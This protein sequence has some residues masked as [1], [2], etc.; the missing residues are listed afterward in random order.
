MNVQVNNSPPRMHFVKPAHKTSRK[1]PR[2]IK[3]PAISP[4]SHPFTLNHATTIITKTPP[5]RSPRCSPF[6]HLS[7]SPSSP[8]LTHLAI[9]HNPPRGA[10]AKPAEAE[11]IKRR[12]FVARA[13]LTTPPGARADAPFPIKT[14]IAR[15]Y[16]ASHGRSLIFKA[17]FAP[18]K[19][20][21]EHVF[22]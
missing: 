6:L 20:H 15:H 17:Q 13:S 8:N 10:R 5:N 19:L 14:D 12:R 18:E 3:P 2:A 22:I 16:D 9:Y 7:H 1:L 11:T 4:Y 21:F